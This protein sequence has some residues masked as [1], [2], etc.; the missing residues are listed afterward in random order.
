M[1]CDI[2]EGTGLD[3]QTYYDEEITRPC[4]CSLG[5]KEELD[6]EHETSIHQGQTYQLEAGLP[7]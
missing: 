4:A 3:I 7:F 5:L 2:C 1:T 6:M